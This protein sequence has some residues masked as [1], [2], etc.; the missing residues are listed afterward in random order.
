[1][2]SLAALHER[3]YQFFYRLCNLKNYQCLIPLDFNKPW[4]Q[5]L[6]KQKMRLAIVIIP[7]ALKKIADT[8]SAFIIG[9]ILSSQ[10]VDWLIYYVLCW[11]AIVILVYISDFNFALIGISTQSIQYYAHQ[12]LLKI[13]PIFHATRSTG[14]ILAKIERANTAYREILDIGIHDLMFTFIGMITAVVALWPYSTALAILAFC[15]LSSLAIIAVLAFIFNNDAFITPYIQAEDSVRSTGVENL[16]QISL[17]RSTFAGNEANR[18]LRQKTTHA[19]YV[20]RATWGAFYLL[21]AIMRILYFCIFLILALYIF[22]LIKKGIMSSLLGTTL[23]ITFMRGT[24]DI[25]K[26]GRRVYWCISATEKIDDLFKFLSTFGKQTFPVLGQA[27]HRFELPLT[28]E[29]NLIIS[30]Q[31]LR[32]AYN[33]TAHIFNDHSLLLTVNHTQ[34]NKLYGIIGPS[35]IGK[36]TLLSILGG[37]LKPQEGRVTLNGINVYSIDDYARRTLISM[38]NQTASTLRGTVRENLIFGLP[39]DKTLYTD[40]ELINVLQ[41]VGLWKTLSEKKGLDT[42]IGEGGLT[43]SGGQRQRFNFASLYLRAQYYKPMLI[44]MDEPTSSLDEV[45][46]RAVSDMID[47]LAPHSVIF[48]IAHRLNTIKNAHALLDISMSKETKK[49]RFYPPEILVKKSAYYRA[50]LEGNVSL[51]S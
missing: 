28:K 47:E 33:T 20:E 6:A 39:T 18:T 25:T 41:R 21:N 12:Y 42:F 19:I 46:E 17:I 32:F 44:L 5:L 26:V 15:L 34:K 37:Q 50:I 27:E 7:Q 22:A 13:D 23:L 35:G 31:N 1:M 9:L 2:F 14:Q 40:E 49:L 8:L 43:L 24:Y 51:E 48:V 10:R 45:S 16:S 29:N 4:W 38:Q 11:F 3:Y 36:T 30:A